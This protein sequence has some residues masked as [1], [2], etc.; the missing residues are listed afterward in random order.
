MSRIIV[1]P[2]GDI[3]LINLGDA[4]PAE[5]AALVDVL[6]QVGLTDKEPEVMTRPNQELVLCVH[7][8]KF[9]P[10]SYSDVLSIAI[11]IA[12]LVWRVAQTDQD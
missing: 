5:V 1:V 9:L 8:T 4:K 6:H 7:K 12:R 11:D 2:H 10:A 3:L